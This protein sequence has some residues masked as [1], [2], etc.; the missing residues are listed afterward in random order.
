MKSPEETGKESPRVLGGGG[1][2]K[3]LKERSSKED[4]GQLFNL[5]KKNM[6]KTEIKAVCHK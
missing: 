2:A 1:D 5:H 3:T 4:R 6:I